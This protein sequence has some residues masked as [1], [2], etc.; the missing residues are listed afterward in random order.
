[1]NNILEADSILLEF[2]LKRVLTDIYMRFEE[3]NITGILGRNGAGKSCLL[4]IIFGSLEAQ[5]SN[6]RF[7]GVSLQN[8]FQHSDRIRYMPQFSFIPNNLRLTKVFKL[9]GVD[10]EMFAGDFPE[11][12]NNLESRFKTFSFGQKRLIETYLILKSKSDFILLDEPFSYL[13]PLN[14]EKLKG[15]IQVEKKHKGIVITDHLYREL[16]GITDVLYLISD[17]KSHQI[18]HQKELQLYGYVN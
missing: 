7:N 6:I 12:T 2:G 15:I 1:M 13:M 10:P 17:G 9:F 5:N 3:G 4:K 16:T 18:K 11:I 14:I 8:P